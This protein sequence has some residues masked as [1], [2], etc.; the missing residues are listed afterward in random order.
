MKKQSI[1]M[2]IC[3]AAILILSSLYPVRTM[4]SERPSKGAMVYVP[5]YSSIFHG[6]RRNEI[7]LT[8]TLSIRNTDPKQP[9][10]ITRVDYY[11]SAGKMLARY[12]KS[13]FTLNALASSSFLIPESE[14]RG[15]AGAKFI[16]EWHAQDPV[17]KPIIE[18]IMIGTR[19]Q[20]GIS[21]NSRGKEIAE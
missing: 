11:D 18:T 13:P 19:G 4:P 12:I 17:S 10:T 3:S 2:M 1:V 7:R 5:A 20:Q 9:I 6:D 21:F 16:V 8:V 15:G 14:N